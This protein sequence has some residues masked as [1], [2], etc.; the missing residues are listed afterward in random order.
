MS[1]KKISELPQAGALNLDDLLALVQD[2]ETRRVSLRSL[3]NELQLN[4]PQPRIKIRRDTDNSH[5]GHDQVI[6]Y[7]EGSDARFMKYNPEYWLYRYKRADLKT[8]VNKESGN[9]EQVWRKRRFVHPSHQHGNKYA[10]DSGG[11]T[12]LFDGEQRIEIG[13]A[14]GLI[15]SRNTEWAVNSSPLDE[16]ILDLAPWTY[17][18]INGMNPFTGIA[19][20]DF[21]LTTQPTPRGTGSNRSRF[22]V[23]KVRIAI[24]NPDEDPEY[25]KIFGPFSET[26]ILFPFKFED[27]WTHL[28]YLL[29]P[30]A[31]PS[32]LK[33]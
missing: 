23:C 4:I 25:P 32:L 14:S 31:S 20:D 30:E 33:R 1:D 19:P 6:A 17:F 2:G 5:F 13:G 18:R 21:P 11:G 22:V 15:P 26:F 7:W 12:K 3:I 29:G 8:F 10:Q 9:R 24:D 16:T 27:E 28:Q